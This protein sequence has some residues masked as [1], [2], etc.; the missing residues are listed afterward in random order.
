MCRV[1]PTRVLT[2][3][4]P[5]ASPPSSSSKLTVLGPCSS[6]VDLHVVDR[7]V[8]LGHDVQIRALE[9]RRER[10]LANGGCESEMLVQRL[11]V[12]RR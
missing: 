10:L 9:G 4:G 2:R 12:A 3:A 1:S 11:L 6:F 7:R 5:T 8:A